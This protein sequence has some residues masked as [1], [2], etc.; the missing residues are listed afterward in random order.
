MSEGV[1]L[2]EYIGKYNF[3]TPIVI[4][5]AFLEQACQEQQFWCVNLTKIPNID[6][7]SK[8]L[9]FVSYH[10]ARAKNGR[11]QIVRR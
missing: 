1:L 4:F 5:M 7:D 2:E 11:Q 8:Y 10:L 6:G 3:F 9:V